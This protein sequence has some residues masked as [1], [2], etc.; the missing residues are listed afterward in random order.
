MA[1]GLWQRAGPGGAGGKKKLERSVTWY[2]SGKGGSRV[3][4]LHVGWSR[5]WVQPMA[6]IQDAQPSILNTSCMP[7]TVACCGR[8]MRVCM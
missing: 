8:L 3:C 6:F 2:Q 4:R 1:A 7:M 5:P